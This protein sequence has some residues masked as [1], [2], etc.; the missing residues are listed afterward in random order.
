QEYPFHFEIILEYEMFENGFSC[1]QTYRNTGTSAMP[2]YAGFHPY[3]ALN[4]PKDQIKLDY[5][6]SRRFQYNTKL[7]DIIGELPLFETPAALTLPELNE[8]LVELLESK[9]VQ[10]SFPD[11]SSFKMK[12]EGIEDPHLFRFLQLY[13]IPTEPFLCI[14][15]W[16]GH[17]NSLNSVAGVRWLAP[18][19]SEQG[20]LRFEF[21]S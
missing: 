9:Q 19:T 20:I 4:A 3:F 10:L 7:T 5:K 6:P 15:P 8:S 1:K 13:H 11:N 2:Y 16:M 12:A 17:P 21:E 18:H 14:E